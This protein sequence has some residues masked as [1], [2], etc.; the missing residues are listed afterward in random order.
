VARPTA[1][2]H[3]DTAQ[4]RTRSSSATVWSACSAPAN[5]SSAKWPSCLPDQRTTYPSRVNRLDNHL[6][7]GS[8]FDR[9]VKIELT[10]NTW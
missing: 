6:I 8:N 3:T 2:Q 1:Q 10:H 9:R 7:A 5:P 4:D